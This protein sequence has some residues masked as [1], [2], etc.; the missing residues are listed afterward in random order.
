MNSNA[1]HNGR[2]Q[3]S[4]QECAAY[5]YAYPGNIPI[6]LTAPHG[7]REFIQGMQGR[8][9]GVTA[10]DLNTLPMI[11]IVRDIMRTEYD[12][13]PYVVGAYFSRKYIDA[14]RSA[15]S[16]YEDENAREIYNAYHRQIA[17]YIQEMKNKFPDNHPLLVD[18][19]GQ[20][21]YPDTIFRGT[22]NTKTLQ[23]LLK[24]A[25]EDA[26][27]G[28]ESILGV[29]H[30]YGYRVFP[31]L[32][33]ITEQEHRS[34][35]GGFTVYTYGS[36]CK[37]GINAV[38]LEFGSQLRTKDQLRCTAR[39]FAYALDVFNRRWQMRTTTPKKKLTLGVTLLGSL[40]WILYH[41]CFEPR[42]SGMRSG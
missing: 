33:S 10:T 2:K 3:L 5:V 25:G 9:Y 41:V 26:V 11:K 24:V 28:A 34:Y 4:P 36:H 22:R 32:T 35:D 37:Q 30:K 13:V 8:R 31:S 39:D 17:L 19:H 12:C 18:I 15:R 29:L 20:S 6:L 7:G 38:Q 1:A 27:I 14:N 16:A 42:S 40:S 21:A 23:D